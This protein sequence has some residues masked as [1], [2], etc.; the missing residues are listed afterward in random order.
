MRIVDETQKQFTRFSGDKEGKDEE[1]A[2]AI[3]PSQG[4]IIRQY[5]PPSTTTA[6]KSRSS[7]KA[8]RASSTASSIAAASSYP[9]PI[10]QVSSPGGHSP[11]SPLSAR[12]QC[13]PDD[14]IPRYVSPHIAEHV[15]AY[16]LQNFVQGSSLRNHGYLDFLFPLLANNP[17]SERGHPLPLAFTAAAIISFAA[18]QKVPE[19]LPKAEAI[20]LR[21]LESTFLAIGDSSRARDNSTLA[22][23]TLLTTFEVCIMLVNTPSPCVFGADFDF[24]T[25]QLRPSRPSHQKAEAFG[26]HLDGAVA[27]LKMRG[28]DL[29][30]TVVGRK[31]FL[32]LRSLLVSSQRFRQQQVSAL[33]I[34]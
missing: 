17:S 28:K 32:I 33:L 11:S 9:S 15:Y 26:S 27:L 25:Q 20:Y 4:V 10:S 30:Q 31:I 2:S 5:A 16:F 22:C 29:F 24:V 34:I 8:K 21:A 1:D 14:S 3:G 23:V 7:S 18:R 13:S 19:L 6:P 12:T